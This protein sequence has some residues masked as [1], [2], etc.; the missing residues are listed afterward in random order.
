MRTAKP[1][2]IITRINDYK[3][4]WRLVAL[5]VAAS[6]ILLFVT[7]MNFA[8]AATNPPQGNVV[9]NFSGLTVA[10]TAEIKNK[11]ITPNIDTF[12]IDV[13]NGIKNT[14]GTNVV[15]NDD[16]N[17]TGKTWF[18]DY[19]DTPKIYTSSIES[20]M[21]S[22]AM[23][24]SVYLDPAYFLNAAN[25]R[26]EFG[27]STPVKLWSDLT[28]PDHNFDIGGVIKNS[29]TTNGSAVK[30]DD[31]LQVVG[32][33]KRGDGVTNYLEPV[34]VTTPFNLANGVS[35]CIQAVCDTAKG[36]Y[37]SACS[38]NFAGTKMYKLWAEKSAGYCD[39]CAL[40][41]LGSSVTIKVKSAC[42]KP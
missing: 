28:N 19:I 31:D 36:Y 24:G 16:L 42:V 10:G 3:T 35:Q 13:Q 20:P 7:A 18:D 2:F 37:P 11:L 12:N 38:G 33:I 17:V 32:T 34:E 30:I 8:G 41:D 4:I 39:L 14:K 1:H 23:K 26:G 25:I 22:I 5:I 29:G 15:I 6:L 27:K 21:N 9:P 40:N